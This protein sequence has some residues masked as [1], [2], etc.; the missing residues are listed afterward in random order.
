MCTPVS[1]AGVGLKVRAT[2]GN[3]LKMPYLLIAR[4]G[5]GWWGIVQRQNSGL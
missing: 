3:A 5:E 1:S 4:H 2:L